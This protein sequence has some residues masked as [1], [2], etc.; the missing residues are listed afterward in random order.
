[1]A[2]SGQIELPEKLVEVFSG[3]ALYRGAYGGRGSAKCFG[4]GT[5]VLRAD[6]SLVAVEDVREGDCLLGPD[7]R[8]RRVCGLAQGIAPLYRVTQK[9]GMSYVVNG[10]HILVLERSRHA[11]EDFGSIS[12]AGNPQRVNGRYAGYDTGLGYSL[13][14]AADYAKKPERFKTQHFGFRRPI[15]GMHKALTVD[16][17]FLGLWLGD[18]TAK[19][20]EITNPDPEIISFIY[21]YAEEENWVVSEMGN[22]RSASRFYIGSEYSRAGSFVQQLR[23]AGVF[24]NKHIPEEYFGASTEQRLALLAGLVDTDGH[25]STGCIAIAQSREAMLDD[26]IRLAHGLG[27]KASKRY[28]PV[29]LNGKICA[30]WKCQIGGDID[31][32]PLRVARKRD[33]ARVVKNKDW[34]RTRVDIEEIGVG[35]YFGFELD[36]DHLFMLADGTVTHNSRSFAKMAAVHGLRC[37]LAK[38]SGVIVCGR[39]FQNS[40]DESSMAEVKQA[41]ETEPWLRDNYEIG[42]KFIRTRDGRIDFSFVG[43]RRNIESVKS[44]ARIRLLWVDEAEPVSEMAWQKAIPTVREENAEIWVT[45][46]PERRASATNQRFRVN[47]P[48]NSKI[49]ELNWRDNAWFPSTLDQIRREDEAKRPEQYPHIWEGEYAIA[50]AGAYYAKFLSDAS[51]EGRIGRVTRDPLMAVRAYCDLGGTGARSDAFAMWVCQFVGREVRVLDY[52]EAVGQSLGV[53]V[54]WLR[55]RGWGKAQIFLPMTA[56]PMTGFMTCRSRVLLG[57]PGSTSR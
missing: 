4:R 19:A 49:V 35:A 15:V 53:H 25:V 13:I 40:L 6:A 8:P 44:T 33:A 37:A 17:Y 30:A 28:T 16:P 29:P 41:I 50:H 11:A 12:L 48:E 21:A 26:I 3:E 55:E 9:T 43:L 27:F 5:K 39:E 54:D 32:L 20:S 57:R 22:G 36:G 56:R 47:P 38:E 18:G 1:L 23:V 14:T 34:R 10:D 46:N 51:Q 7:G 45:W 31:R 42:E 24:R 52:Y 2:K